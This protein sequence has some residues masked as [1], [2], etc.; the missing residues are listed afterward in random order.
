MSVLNEIV[1]GGDLSS[2]NNQMLMTTSLGS[3]SGQLFLQ[4]GGGGTGPN[5]MVLSVNNSI[6][7]KYGSISSINQIAPN[8]KPNSTIA[9]T[10]TA[11]TTTS[12]SNNQ[13]D[14]LIY[15]VLAHFHFIQTYEKYISHFIIKV[16]SDLLGYG[17]SL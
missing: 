2:L 13:Y 17:S 15:Q 8:T 6:M 4:S 12:A 14:N 9:A 16:S 11:A 1:N 3:G 7:S 10:S 5:G